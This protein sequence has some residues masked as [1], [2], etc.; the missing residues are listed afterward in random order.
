MR[1]NLKALGDAVIAA[2]KGHVQD[3]LTTLSKRMDALDER[4]SAIPAGEKGE[5]GES[6]KGDKGDPGERGE[7]GES[8]Q[9]ERG[10][11]GEPGDP[12]RDGKSVSLDDMAPL[13][14]SMHA[15]WA[16]EWERRAQDTLSKAVDSIPAPR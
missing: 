4:I 6:I 16:L 11:K 2:V 9:G 5:P 8:I 15:K 3:A 7:R 10:E 13:I 14:E 1:D 12:G